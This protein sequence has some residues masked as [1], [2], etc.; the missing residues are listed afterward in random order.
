MSHLVL[1]SCYLFFIGCTL[2]SFIGVVVERL[3]HQLRWREEYKENWNIVFPRSQCDHCERKIVWYALIPVIGYIISLAKC[4]YC[5]KRV[6]IL[7]PLV[8]IFCGFLL[9][10][11]FIKHGLTTDF[12]LISILALSLFFLAWIDIN[13]QWLP[14]VVTIPLFWIGLL[15]SPLCNDPLLR[16]QGA[17]LGFSLPLFAMWAVSIL[18]KTDVLAGGDI[19]LITVAGAWFGLDKML[20]YIIASNICFV[21][22]SLPARIKGNVFLPMGPALVFGFVYCYL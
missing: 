8:E 13:E 12:Y 17:A 15:F 11:L 18:K 6:S 9:V 3:P 2:G 4:K 20:T 19:A 10:Y 16:I 22:Y 1:I 14:A 7:Y 5:A 21:L